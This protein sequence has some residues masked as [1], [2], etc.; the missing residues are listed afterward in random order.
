MPQL[1]REVEV[2]VS[3]LQSE[4]FMLEEQIAE[5]ETGNR[6]PRVK[7]SSTQT[8]DVDTLWKHEASKVSFPLLN[9]KKN[10]EL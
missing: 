8:E 10:K 6:K 2:E 4:F 7:C 3:R 1:E 5:L 9:I